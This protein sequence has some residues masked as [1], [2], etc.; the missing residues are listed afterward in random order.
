MTVRFRWARISVAVV[1]LVCAFTALGA[2]GAVPPA[3]AAAAAP[4][5]TFNGSSLPLILSA[6]AGEQIALDC[7]GLSPAHPYLFMEVSLLLGIDP[8]AAPLLNGSI[9]SLSGLMA[10]LAALPEINP[11]ALA[12]PLSDTSGN[13]NYTYTLPTSQAPDPNATCPPSNA[14]LNMGLIGCA[15][16]MIDLT[17]FKV[18]AAGSGLVNYAGQSL[19]PPSPTL[20][21]SANK[22]TPGQ[23]VNVSD[24]VR[25]HHLLVVVNRH[26]PAGPARWLGRPTGSDGHLGE[27]QE[28]HSD[29]RS[30]RRHGNPGGLQL[31]SADPAHDLRRIHRASDQREGGGDRDLRGAVAGR[32]LLQH[33]HRPSQDHIAAALSSPLA[34][35]VQVT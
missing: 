25:R 20:A 24:V 34:S 22:A 29:D 12:F 23:V 32:N 35:G 15:V 8:N 10:L 11:A 19:L 17:T 5:C 14:E 6:S 1:A 13:L 3:G 28:E 18:V 9:T 30:Q 7:T 16:A 21:L 26:W 4:A 33:R 31:P 27:T 2:S